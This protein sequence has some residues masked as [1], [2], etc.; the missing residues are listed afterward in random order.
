MVNQ[1]VSSK[2]FEIL[3]QERRYKFNKII[4]HYLLLLL[5]YVIIIII[6]IIIIKP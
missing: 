2:Y 5:T 6:I 3:C 4:G 1:F